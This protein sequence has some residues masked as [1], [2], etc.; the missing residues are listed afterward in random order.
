MM[1][2]WSDVRGLAGPITPSLQYS[3]TPFFL[4]HRSLL[5]PDLFF[6]RLLF[7]RRVDLVIEGLLGTD[8]RLLYNLL[9]NMPLPFFR[10]IPDLLLN[11]RSL[12]GFLV[13]Q[14]RLLLGC[15]RLHFFRQ[16][17]NRYPGQIYFPVGDVV[18]Q[19]RAPQ[20]IGFSRFALIEDG[21]L[22]QSRCRR[23]AV[24][25]FRYRDPL[26]LGGD[27]FSIPVK[28]TGGVQF[29]REAAQLRVIRCRGLYRPPRLFDP[30]ELPPARE[31]IS[32]QTGVV[33]P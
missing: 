12:L 1:E 2:Y 14:V 10:K 11:F 24:D 15:H 19:L 17:F 33:G 25:F 27:G 4:I 8:T 13:N 16:F 23:R 20:Q 29:P 3:I 22:G 21:P 31:A 7:D 26:F 18:N 6:R 32:R 5:D 9:L 30:E 28:N